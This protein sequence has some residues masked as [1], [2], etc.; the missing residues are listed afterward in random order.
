MLEPAGREGE[1]ERG[2][3]GGREGGREGRREGRM[4]FFRA[5]V[6]L[7]ARCDACKQNICWSRQ[8][9]RERGREG[10]REGRRL[11]GLSFLSSHDATLASG[12]YVGSRR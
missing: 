10:G 4:P 5:L 3:E 8:V 11:A 1:R 7:F 6:L 12:I 2:K 9:G